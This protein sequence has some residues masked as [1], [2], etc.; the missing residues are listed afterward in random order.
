MPITLPNGPTIPSASE[1]QAAG[2]YGYQGWPDPEAGLDYQATGG[3]GK[4]T[5][6][7]PSALGGGGAVG[8]TGG[9]VAGSFGFNWEQAEKDA[10]EKLRPYYEEVLAEA[11]YDINLATQRLQDDYDRGVRYNAEDLAVAQEG[12]NMM[13]P[14]ERNELLT[15]LN[16]RG[17][18]QS[19]I[20]GEEEQFLTD[21]QRRRREALQRA[22][23][24]QNELAGITRQRGTE[25]VTTAGSRQIRDIGEEKKQ[26]ALDLADTQYQRD[27]NRWLAETSRFNV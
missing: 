27:W 5:L 1:L 11:N 9:Q 26:K 6:T 25:D 17:V 2:F 13:E 20:R 7:N 10:L 4:G 23:D 8:A 16:R 24:R 15:S 22:I 12:W 21:T 18:L 19:T 14:R 3:S